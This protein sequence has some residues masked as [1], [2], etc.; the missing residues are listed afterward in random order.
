MK[1]WG[2][3]RASLPKSDRG[4]MGAA[5]LLENECDDF[6]PIPKYRAGEAAAKRRR[7]AEDRSYELAYIIHTLITECS[8]LVGG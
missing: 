5:V 1:T 6:G 3:R 2:D 7:G 8:F 4:T